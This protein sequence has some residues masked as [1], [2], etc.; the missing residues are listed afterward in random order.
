MYKQIRFSE[1]AG[2]KVQAADYNSLSCNLCLSFT[3][4]TFVAVGVDTAYGLDRL[5]LYEPTL[6]LPIDFSW[7]TL[8]QDV[9]AVSAAEAKRALKKRDEIE[10]IEREKHEREVYER[11]RKKFG[12]T[13]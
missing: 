3:D 6:A 2:R 5:E 9:G 10:A 8:L 12:N 7:D 4:K 11:L 1:I 13:P